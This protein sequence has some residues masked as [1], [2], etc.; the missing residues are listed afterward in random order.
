MAE[1]NTIKAQ[2]P[3]SKDDP[4]EIIDRDDRRPGYDPDNGEHVVTLRF[5]QPSFHIEIS[6]ASEVLSVPSALSIASPF[7]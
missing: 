7:H 4:L 5:W 2:C 1:S 6:F 3:A